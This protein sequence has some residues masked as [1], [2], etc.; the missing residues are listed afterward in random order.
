MGQP[1]DRKAATRSELDEL[2][3]RVSEWVKSTEGTAKLLE[4][5]KSVEAAIESAE[6]AA[7]INPELLRKPI[8]L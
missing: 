7:H 1:D 8:T 2:A 3:T 5:K 4:T 6:K